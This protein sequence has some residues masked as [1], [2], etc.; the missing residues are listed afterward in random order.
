MSN[1]KCFLKTFFP[2]PRMYKC[3]VINKHL[4]QIKLTIENLQKES[5]KID[6]GLKEVFILMETLWRVG[7]EKSV[8]QRS[9]SSQP[10]IQNHHHCHDL[11]FWEFSLLLPSCLT[12]PLFPQKNNMAALS[13]NIYWIEK[14]LSSKIYC[15]VFWQENNFFLLHSICCWM[16]C[17]GVGVGLTGARKKMDRHSTSWW[18]QCQTAS[19]FFFFKSRI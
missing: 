1:L 9:S 18:M 16:Y 8:A 14:F 3:K 11:T 15:D 10:I 7:G 2:L 12:Y 6:D 13:Q 5:G 4:G 17:V 19:T